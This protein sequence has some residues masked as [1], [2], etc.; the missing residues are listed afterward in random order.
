MS[1]L[2]TSTCLYLSSRFYNQLCM[3][4]WYLFTSMLFLAIKIW[5]MSFCFDQTYRSFNKVKRNLLSQVRG[6]IILR[7]TVGPCLLNIQWLYRLLVPER[8]RHVKIFTMCRSTIL[9]MFSTFNLI[10]AFKKF[11]N[12]SFEQFKQ[13][14]WS[15]LYWTCRNGGVV[16]NNIICK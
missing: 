13:N 9:I 4:V 3:H 8:L 15:G 1:F 5:H 10:I 7:T 12:K 14:W 16:I 11:Q 2:C 6:Q